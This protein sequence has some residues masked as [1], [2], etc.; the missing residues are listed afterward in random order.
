MLEAR[1][2]FYFRQNATSESGVRR[3]WKVGWNLLGSGNPQSGVLNPGISSGRQ[4][5]EMSYT[6]KRNKKPGVL[7]RVLSIEVK[8]WNGVL[9]PAKEVSMLTAIMFSRSHHHR[10]FLL[11]GPLP[12]SWSYV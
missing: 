5:P 6:D 11:K 4:L 12:A 1:E 9:L 2:G 7:R 8:Y 3:L 10:V